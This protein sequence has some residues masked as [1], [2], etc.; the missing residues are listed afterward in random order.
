MVPPNTTAL[1]VL[2][3]AILKDN[4]ETI[5]RFVHLEEAD[6]FSIDAYA[7]EEPLEQICIKLLKKLQDRL[8]TKKHD[9]E[10]HDEI[11]LAL[12]KNILLLENFP[13]GGGETQNVNIQAAHVLTSLS[14]HSG[15]IYTDGKPIKP[16]TKSAVEELLHY[17][18]WQTKLVG[19]LLAKA[20]YKTELENLIPPGLEVHSGNLYEKPNQTQT[21]D[22][23]HNHSHNHNDST[24]LTPEKN[25]TE[26]MKSSEQETEDPEPIWEFEIEEITPNPTNDNDE[27]RKED[28]IG[29]EEEK[30]ED[31]ITNNVSII[32][33]ITQV[34][35]KKN[36]APAKE[37]KITGRGP[38]G[39][40]IQFHGPNPDA[41]I[42]KC[43]KTVEDL[44]QSKKKTLNASN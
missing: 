37:Y 17:P 5:L 10:T 20:L 15:K 18:I 2:G 14:V 1:D 21:H 25:K 24:S 30:N 36:P 42:E 40:K 7:L 35:P 4:L 29:R 9:S 28:A 26:G 33:W 6:Y 3:N 38:K 12:A 31:D 16:C 11:G 22:H 13:P 39:Q 32:P 34:P 41:L 43:K 27:T 19:S 23:N 44:S 8:V